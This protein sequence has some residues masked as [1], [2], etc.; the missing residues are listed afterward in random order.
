VKRLQNKLIDK[1]KKTQ[2]LPPLVQA[3]NN[4]IE[5]SP[6]AVRNNSILALMSNFSPSNFLKIDGGLKSDSNSGFK[7]ERAFLER[8]INHKDT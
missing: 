2:F 7:A 4:Q 6:R 3:S 8:L 5:T 1:K